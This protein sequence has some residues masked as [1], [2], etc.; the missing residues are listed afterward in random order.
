VQESSGTYKKYLQSWHNILLHTKNLSTTY[1]GL[2]QYVVASLVENYHAVALHSGDRDRPYEAADFDDYKDNGP[3]MMDLLQAI[4][5]SD[6][7]NF[8]VKE[9]DQTRA[10]LEAELGR[11][12]WQNNKPPAPDAWYACLPPFGCACQC[13]PCAPASTHTPGCSRRMSSL[14]A[15]DRGVKTSLRPGLSCRFARPV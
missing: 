1:A 12:K 15:A 9:T 8:L 10:K 3:G 2:H 11:G 13:Q 5:R 7:D 6:N 14:A 4:E